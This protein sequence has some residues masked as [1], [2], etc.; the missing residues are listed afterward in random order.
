MFGHCV[1]AY[2][3]DVFAKHG[4]TFSRLQ[5]DANNGLGDVYKKIACLTEQQRKEIEADIQA[6]YS[7][8]APIAMVD[9]D[10]GITNLHVPSDIIIDNSMPTAIRGGGKMWNKDDKE[11]DFLAT[12]PDRGYAGVFGEVI[13][14]CK[15]NGAFDPKTMGSCP[16][17]GLMAQKAEEYGSHPCTFEIQKRGA[18]RIVVNSTDQILLGHKVNVGDIYRS[19][20]TK[21]APIKDW[22]KLAVTRCRANN[23]PNNDKSCKAIFFL[24]SART[25]D[26]ILMNKVRAYLPQ[27]KPEGLDIEVMSPN[28]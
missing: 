28:G 21:D 15:K 18:V 24:D 6:T 8:R 22:V 27:F 20:Q 14:F 13:E 2:Y 25:H 5:I 3:K 9:S 23:F 1:K 10:R 17:V 4:A 7:K 11:E 19:C 12:I 26:V 16:N